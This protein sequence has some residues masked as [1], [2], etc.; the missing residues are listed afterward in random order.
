MSLEEKIRELGLLLK[1]SNKEKKETIQNQIKLLEIA[2]YKRDRY[3]STAEKKR[4]EVVQ[5]AF[6]IK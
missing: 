2:I 1:Q 5:E 6:G 3:M 4:I